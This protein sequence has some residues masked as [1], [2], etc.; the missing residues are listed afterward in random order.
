MKLTLPFVK[1][2]ASLPMAFFWNSVSPN[3][4]NLIDNQNSGSRNAAT[5]KAKRTYIPLE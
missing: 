1:Y 3:S 5:A 4:Q 2:P